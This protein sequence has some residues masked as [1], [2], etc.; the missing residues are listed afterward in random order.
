[1]L[2]VFPFTKFGP[3]QNDQFLTPPWVRVFYY[4]N[5]KASHICAFLLICRGYTKGYHECDADERTHSLPVEE[6]LTGLLV[7]SLIWVFELVY[8]NPFFFFHGS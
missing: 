7:N 6:S 2:R 8:L 5:L 1:M 4:V 3:S